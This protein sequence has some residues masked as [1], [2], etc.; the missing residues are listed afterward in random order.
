MI[1][2]RFVHFSAHPQLVQQHRQLPGHRHHSALL[3]I[4]ASPLGQLQPP[5]TQVAIFPKRSQDVVRA[6]YHQRSQV[7][8]SFLADV[9]LRLAVAGVPPPWTQP[10]I[11]AQVPAP[12]ESM[13]I[14]HRQHVRQRN[15]RSDTIDL[16]QL[17]T[18]G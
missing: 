17:A 4:A 18:S 15:Q 9:E 10:Y 16:L 11:A 3:G 13:R 8:V 1:P 7:P 5:S 2:E 6:L 14:V 12:P